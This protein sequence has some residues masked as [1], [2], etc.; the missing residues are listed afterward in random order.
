MN[1]DCS[2][3]KLE[4]GILVFGIVCELYYILLIYAVSFAFN[5]AVLLLLLIVCC[6]LLLLLLLFSFDMNERANIPGEN[7]QKE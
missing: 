3:K 7:L 4:T 5:C 2:L 6:Y 1:I